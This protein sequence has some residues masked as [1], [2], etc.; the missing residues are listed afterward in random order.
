MPASKHIKNFHQVTEWLYRGGQPDAKGV[1][2][3]ARMEIGTVVSLRWTK[4]T[5]E[6]E[7]V[8]V[9]D[10][11]MKF[12]SMPL[13]YWHLPNQSIINQFLS[14]LDN[15]KDRPV[16]VHCLHGADRT[17]L[18]IAIFRIDRCGWSLDDAY[19]EMVEC[20]FHRFRIRHFKWILGRYA[21]RAA[22]KGI[23]IEQ[24]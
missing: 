18:L 16:F 21:R 24:A 5:I 20:G 23:P 9:V 19:R 22:S 1:E 13:N 6:T 4:R 2:A 7:Q 14:I 17:G 11:G 3:L 15:A 12:I 8:R 10:Q